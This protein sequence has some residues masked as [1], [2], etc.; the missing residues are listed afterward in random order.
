MPKRVTGQSRRLWQSRKRG[1]SSLS[2]DDTVQFFQDFGQ[3]W[4]A[5]IPVG[6]SASLGGVVQE[7]ENRGLNSR[8][9]S[10]AESDR[11]SPNKVVLDR[12]NFALRMRACSGGT[13]RPCLSQTI[14]VSWCIARMTAC[15]DGDL[16][17]RNPLA[18]TILRTA[19]CAPGRP[20]RLSPQIAQKAVRGPFSN[21]RKFSNILV[22]FVIFSVLYSLGDMFWS[23]KLGRFDEANRPRSCGRQIDM[24]PSY[25]WPAIID[26]HND[27][28]V[29][30]DLNQVPN[31]KVRWAAVIAAQFTRSPFAVRLPQSPSW[32]P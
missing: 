10:D 9:R 6:G 12:G 19:C 11:H 22:F 32:P 20:T 28:S 27:A 4:P 14:R 23:A 3:L 8:A 25:K 16:L 21:L 7:T 29:V 5:V 18:E 13:R 31:G 2:R 15:E 24:P 1:I 26:A 30:T 17:D